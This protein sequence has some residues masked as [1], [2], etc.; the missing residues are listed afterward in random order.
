MLSFHL[1]IIAGHAEGGHTVGLGRGL[2][3]IRGILRR[4]QELTVYITCIT[5]VVKSKTYRQTCFTQGVPGDLRVI[6]SLQV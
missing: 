2:D 4:E 5:C 3:K 6:A 1:A